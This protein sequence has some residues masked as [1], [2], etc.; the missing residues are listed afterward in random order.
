MLRFH[1]VIIFKLPSHD[2]CLED[3]VCVKVALHRLFGDVRLS[4]CYTV[5]VESY[6]ALVTYGL[7][8]RQP[9]RV[10]KLDIW[11]GFGRFHIRCSAFLA[12]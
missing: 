5:H 6:E 1:I 2:I 12:S 3:S 7:D 9:F 8:Y 10:I 11:E 4:Y